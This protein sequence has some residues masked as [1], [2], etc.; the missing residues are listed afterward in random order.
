MATR[1]LTWFDYPRDSA[2]LLFGTYDPYLVV[3]SALLS[4]F[5][6]SMALQMAGQARHSHHRPTRI[7]ILLTGSLA[8]GGG[9]W[10]MHFV[11]MLSFALCANVRYDRIL[12]LV[13]F[14]P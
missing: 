13:S 6:A 10:A 12:T 1:F 14:L 9:V 2:L 8:L 3:L 5:A 4:V 11:G 7:L